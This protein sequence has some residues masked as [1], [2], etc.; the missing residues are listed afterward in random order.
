MALQAQDAAIRSKA[1]DALTND[2]L[3]EEIYRSL[4]QSRIMLAHRLEGWK[5]SDPRKLEDWFRDAVKA[6]GEQLRHVCRYLKGWRDY[7][8]T[9]CNLSSI[10]LMAAAVTVFKEDFSLRN[11]RSRDDKALLAV[12]ERLPALL[13]APIANP[14]VSG[15]RLDE[16]WSHGQ[17]AEFVEAANELLG[18]VRSAIATGNSAI[19]I[20]ELREAFG[21][22]IPNDFR[23]ISADDGL[24]TKSTIAAPAIQISEGERMRRAE[25][26]T[27]EVEARGT[28]STPWT[29]H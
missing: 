5:P 24:E 8:W 26:A 29:K 11:L 10:A 6:Y 28:Q 23:L 19:A 14:V 22:R 21:K 9:E 25:A 7:H 17:R 27:R 15:Q 18:N 1:Q 13:A 16:N 20:A 3:P 12:C 2:E 4:A